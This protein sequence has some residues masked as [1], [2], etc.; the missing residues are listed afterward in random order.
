MSRELPHDI[1][2]EVTD[3]SVIAGQAAYNK[4]LLAFYDF[5]VLGVSNSFVWKCKTQR[6]LEHYDRNVTANHF[7]VGVGTGFLLDR[8]TFPRATPKITLGDLNMNCLAKVRKRIRRYNPTTVQMNVLDPLT[9]PHGH[10]DS[11]G[12]NYLLHCLPGPFSR[13]LSILKP[14]GTLLNQGGVLFGS[15]IL[16]EEAPHNSFGRFLM[17]TYNRKRVFCN[18]RD[19]SAELRSALLTTFG[20]AQIEIEG[21][22]ALFRAHS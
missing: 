20:N 3:S 10:F 16:G 8:C 15:T 18:T 14:L 1:R 19:T 21:C 12:M 6:L 11:I 5:Y 13:K 17:K 22:V 7:D 2:Q 9:Y 4:A